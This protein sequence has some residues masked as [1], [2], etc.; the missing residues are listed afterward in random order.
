MTKWLRLLAGGL[1][2]MVAAGVTLMAPACSVSDRASDGGPGSGSTNRQA[3]APADEPDAEDAQLTRAR[4]RMVERQLR[5]RDIRDERVLE[6]MRRVPRHRFVAQVP[7]LEAYEDRPHPI[8]DGQTISQPY[9]VAL[10]TVLARLEPPCK[11]LEVGT[12]S[13]YQ[14]AVLAELGCTVY[15]I[16]IV[17][18][19]AKRAE[20]LIAETGYAERVH[21]RF[22][23]GYRGWPEAAPFDAIL[24]T[25]AA[26][27]I[28]EPLQAQLRVGGRLVIPVG[29][30]WQTLEV[31]RRTE[32]GFEREAV[33]AVR[34][35]PM[36]GEVRR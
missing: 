14:A 21:L 32:K 27:H 26:P 29:E 10:M 33:T 25:A 4:E 19:L 28:P 1:S 30:A 35:V 36:T 22:G 20:R 15:S 16:E 8:G 12:G 9:I 7:S 24:V 11:V 18:S 2:G 17:E 13:G 23:D 31:H 34:F 5:G 3:D 6:A